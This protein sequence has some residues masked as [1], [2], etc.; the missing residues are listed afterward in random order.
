MKL[1]HDIENDLEHT[2]PR[3]GGWDS[4]WLFREMTARSLALLDLPRGGR[5]LD[6]ACGM[7]QDTLAIAEAPSGSG[8]GAVKRRA[9]KGRA[10]KGHGVPDRG[11]RLALGLEPSQRMIRFAQTRH[12]ER[13]L[14][15]AAAYVRGL[16]EELPFSAGSFD[17]IL[18][19]GALDHFMDPHLAMEET[20]RILRP[21]GWLVLA[22]ANY[23]SLSCRL[24][25]FLDGMA[26]FPNGK[27]PAPDG[28]VPASDG[29]VPATDRP[30]YEPPP[31]HMT[32]F[33]YR[34]IIGL[35]GPAMH[36]SRVEGISLLWGFPPWGRLLNRVPEAVRG[37]LL[38]TAFL[39]GRVAPS[40]ADVVIV[41][42]VK[43]K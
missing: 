25:R 36:I 22:L 16:G 12:R 39:A 34:A 38:K 2:I 6:L 23:D 8:N 41:R 33:G 18:C 1:A 20:G 19:K 24:G 26:Q 15:R 3:E 37:R 10:V 42:A 40:M 32:L 28:K 5:V 35:F 43:R 14:S 13:G 9:V 17:A 27:A 29:K 30:Y 4:R 31:D 21:G 7:G 11:V